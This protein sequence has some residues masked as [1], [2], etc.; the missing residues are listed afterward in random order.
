[1]NSRKHK[2]SKAGGVKRW[3]GWLA[4]QEFRSEGRNGSDEFTLL[5]RL[6]EKEE[7]MEAGAGCRVKGCV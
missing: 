4:L 5:R 3:R 1:M 7:R 6:D 2:Y